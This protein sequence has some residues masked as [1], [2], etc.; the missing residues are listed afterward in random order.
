MWNRG[1][2][3]AQIARVFSREDNLAGLRD[4]YA[5][6]IEADAQRIGLKQRLARLLLQ[7]NRHEEALPLYQSGIPL[8]RFA[9]IPAKC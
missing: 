7:M 5:T 2:F 3:C 1:S 6:L 9:F 4:F 8:F